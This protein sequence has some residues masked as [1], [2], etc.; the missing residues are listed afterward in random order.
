[1]HFLQVLARPA[2]V[3]NHDQATELKLMGDYVPTGIGLVT[4]AVANLDTPFLLV[5]GLS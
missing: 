3:L 4:H 2:V 5:R 1:M